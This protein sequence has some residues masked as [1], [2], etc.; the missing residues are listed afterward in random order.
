MALALL[1]ASIVNL[2]CL[3]GTTVSTMGKK[4]MGLLRAYR[5]SLVAPSE[6]RRAGAE[7]NAVGCREAG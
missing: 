1:G 7:P 3:L 4:K 2:F 5:N 6:A